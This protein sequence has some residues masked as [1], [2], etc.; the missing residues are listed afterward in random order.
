MASMEK[1][2]GGELEGPAFVYE[3]YTKR[4][5]VCDA[6]VAAAIEAVAIEMKGGA[7][8]PASRIGDSIANDSLGSVDGDIV[9][10]AMLQEKLTVAA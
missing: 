7:P 10:S 9:L 2:M 4:M 1:C 3:Q 6:E 8:S 5:M